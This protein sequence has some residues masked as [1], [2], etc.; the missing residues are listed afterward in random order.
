MNNTFSQRPSYDSSAPLQKS[1][2]SHCGMA[3]NYNSPKSVSSSSHSQKRFERF[4]NNLV[5]KDKFIPVGTEKSM[6]L[7]YDVNN[8]VKII[9]N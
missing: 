8:S 9:E 6:K 5:M 4:E 3:Y 2:S 1:N 7:G